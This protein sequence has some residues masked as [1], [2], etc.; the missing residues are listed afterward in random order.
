M[1][2]QLHP[3][4][5]TTNPQPKCSPRT[6]RTSYQPN[7][8]HPRHTTNKQRRH[9][10]RKR[11]MHSRHPEAPRPTLRIPIGFPKYAVILISRSSWIV[12]IILQIRRRRRHRRRRRCHRLG[13]VGGRVGRIGLRIHGREGRRGV[14]RLT[15]WM[16]GEGVMGG[17]RGRE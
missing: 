7:P 4:P 11:A 2:P 13:R 15:R 17:M 5:P 8:Q 14:L 10:Y 9:T 6:P 3:T 1:R 12:H 16:R